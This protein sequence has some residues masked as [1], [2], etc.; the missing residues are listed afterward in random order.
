M[1]SD[2]PQPMVFGSRFWEA[3]QRVLDEAEI[4]GALIGK[5]ERCALCDDVTTRPAGVIP[6]LCPAHERTHEI[7]AVLGSPWGVP[8]ERERLGWLVV[9][10]ASASEPERPTRSNPSSEV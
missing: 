4:R 10:V 2:G 8:P 5:N 1:N 9:R 3:M 6:A 7:I